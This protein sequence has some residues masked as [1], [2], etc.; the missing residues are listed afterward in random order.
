MHDCTVDDVWEG[1]CW[2]HELGLTQ[3]ELGHRTA[4][5]RLTLRENAVAGN[6]GCKVG[7]VHWKRGRD[8]ALRC[9]SGTSKMSDG[10]IAEQKCCV[11]CPGSR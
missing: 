11:R 4:S 8:G 3:V 5:Q 1:D 10:V 2:A 9:P 6:L 7:D